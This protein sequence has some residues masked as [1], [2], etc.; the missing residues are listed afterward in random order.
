M[1]QPVTELDPRFSEPNAV[2]T[3]WEETRRV[4]E[5]AELS[6]SRPFGSTADRM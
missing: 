5:G 2:A 1:Q 3:D 6:G 4:L